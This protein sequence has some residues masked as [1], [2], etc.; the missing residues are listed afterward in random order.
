[1]IEA[2]AIKNYIF[3]LFTLFFIKKYAICM[4]PK[5]KQQNYNC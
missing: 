2:Y 3:T 1:M 5:H 4:A